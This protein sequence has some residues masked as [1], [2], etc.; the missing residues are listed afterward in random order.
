MNNCT[1]E[2]TNIPIKPL[3]TIVFALKIIP[4]INASSEIP[5]MIIRYFLLI[6][7]MCDYL[8]SESFSTKE[9]FSL[10]SSAFT[11]SK[12]SM[13]EIVSEI[14]EFVVRATRA[15]SKV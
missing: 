5:L 13:R 7:A 15:P 1:R 14:F 10:R 8:Y 2:L 4:I 11:N 9:S 12:R 6:F 3:I